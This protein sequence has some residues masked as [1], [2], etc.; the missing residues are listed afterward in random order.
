MTDPRDF[1]VERR[2]DEDGRM[3]V[4]VTGDLDYA[5]YTRLESELGDVV[6]DAPPE[7][8]VDLAAVTY[9][10]SCGLRVLLAAAQQQRRIGGGFTLRAAS[11]QPRR[12]L[13]LTGLDVVLGG[14]DPADA[15][16]G[17]SAAD[18]PTVQA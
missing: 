13:R 5:T 10:D 4:S 15:P 14:S 2:R 3:V 8:V 17:P 16:A 18:G 11:G 6:A 1:I 9:C 7:L 12:A